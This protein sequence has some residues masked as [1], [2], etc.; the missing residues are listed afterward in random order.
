MRDSQVVT[1]MDKL[2]LMPE[3]SLMVRVLLSDHDLLINHPPFVLYNLLL[4][5]AMVLRWSLITT[6]N[7]IETMMGRDNELHSRRRYSIQCGLHIWF[8]EVELR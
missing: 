2:S 1:E 5:L 3:W 4:T 6:M 8:V 7:T